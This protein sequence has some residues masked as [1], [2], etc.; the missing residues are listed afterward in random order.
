MKKKLLLSAFALIITCQLFAQSYV[1]QVIIANGGVFEWAP[2][3]TDAATIGAY[4]PLTDSYTVFDNIMTESV[5]AVVVDS[6]F[7]YVAAQD[8]IVKYDLDTYQR[9]GIAYYPGIKSLAVSGNH[10]LVGKWYGSGVFFHVY[11]KSSMT[12]LFG[13]SQIN[14]TVDGMVVIGDT[15]YVGYNV[16]GT[17]DACPP[18]GCYSDTLGRIAVVDMSAQMFVRDIEL[19]TTGAGIGK[20]YTDGTSVFA[21]A[22]ERG[23]VIKYNAMT[24]QVDTAY[25]LSAAMGTGF[26]NNML[27]AQYFGSGI[28]SYNTASESFSDTMIV[29]AAYAASAYDTVNSLFYITQTDYFSYGTVYIYNASGVAVDSFSVAVSPE[30]IAIDYRETITA[31]AEQQDI[32]YLLYP[33]P[34]DD[35]INLSVQGNGKAVLTVYDLSGRK[36]ASEEREIKANSISR[37]SLAG[38]EGGMY[39]LHIETASGRAV[40]KITKR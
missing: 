9:A 1:K 3:Y 18:Y 7:A 12:Q 21:I 24:A 13:I 4:N 36:V 26:H 34:A 32:S 2:P 8:S 33:N 40:A 17:I 25:A 39:F 15:A 31:I 6:G 30:G 19:D 11:D 20:L 28:G 29:N 27:Y 35:H 14:T 23:Y 10:L 37:I 22:D 5:Q 16:K 38:L